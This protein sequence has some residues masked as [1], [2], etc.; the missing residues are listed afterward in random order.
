MGRKRL[1]LVGQKFGRL[2]VKENIPDK[3]GYVLCECDCGGQ[4]VIKAT[5]LTRNRDKVQSCGC[6][7]KELMSKIGRANIA[8]NSA[9][10]LDLMRRYGTNFGIIERRSL[11][12]RNKS[13]HTGVWYNAKRG[14]YNAYISS[15]G[16]R[17]HLGTFTRLDDAVAARKEAEEIYYAPLIAA[18][19]A[20]LH[21]TN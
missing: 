19:N 13:G 6:L 2:T 12:K 4:K 21:N 5:M 15:K 14:Y 16:K 9:K 7:R 10:R 18:K 11:N 20:E 8:Q 3:I 1:N 17:I